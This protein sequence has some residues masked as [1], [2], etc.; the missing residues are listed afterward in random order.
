MISTMFRRYQLEM[1]LVIITVARYDV[2]CYPS[3]VAL[4]ACRKGIH[5]NLC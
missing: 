1:E 4:L 5:P 2:W 3:A